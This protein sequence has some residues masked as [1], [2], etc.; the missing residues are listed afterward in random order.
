MVMSRDP[1]VKF[2]KLLF[3]PDSILNFRKSY[4]IWGE[5]A[6]EQKIYKQKTS[7]GVEKTPSQYL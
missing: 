3:L 7:W 6:Q 1:G 2:Q 4:Q 5:L